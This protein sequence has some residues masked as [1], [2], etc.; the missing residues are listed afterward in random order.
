MLVLSRRVNERIF[1]GQAAEIQIEVLNIERGKVR[2][3]I[4]AARDV[5]VYREELW[6]EMQGQTPPAPDPAPDPFLPLP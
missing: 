6:Q 2:L 4:T 5:P 1:V 3:G